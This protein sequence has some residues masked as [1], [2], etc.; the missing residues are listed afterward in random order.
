MK[1]MIIRTVDKQ[2]LFA[3]RTLYRDHL[4]DEA[5]TALPDEAV[6]RAVWNNLLSNPAIRIFVIELNGQL[7]G[8]A[9]LA[10]ISNLT[11]GCR[12]FGLIENVVTHRA[13]RRR[14]LASALLAEVLRI[15]WEEDC[16][17]V[18]LLT[19]TQRTDAHRLYEKLGFTRNEKVGFVAHPPRNKADSP[20][21]SA[22]IHD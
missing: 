16:Y 22:E 9:L 4:F 6:E 10:V 21:S 8:G 14:G 13:Y 3:L 12:P 1:S 11:R 2:E 15:A 19:S 17:K 20:L 5:D 18:M 7:V